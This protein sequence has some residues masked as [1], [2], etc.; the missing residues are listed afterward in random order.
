MS[1][2]WAH[3]FTIASDIPQVLAHSS[4]LHAG[5]LMCI[6]PNWVPQHSPQKTISHI[7]PPNTPTCSTAREPRVSALYRDVKK[8]RKRARG[9]C[10]ALS[11]LQSHCRALMLMAPSKQPVRRGS[12]WPMSPSKRSPSTCR[13]KACRHDVAQSHSHTVFRIRAKHAHTMCCEL[14]QHLT[15]K[16]PHV[17]APQTLQ[18][19]AALSHFTFVS[20][21][22]THLALP[23]NVQHGS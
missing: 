2:F 23:G 1:S 17:Y 15:R 5:Q 3:P 13:H 20:S 7:T 6:C 14:T 21:L 9:S 10:P 16:C 19:V 12:P 4:S 11:A 18:Q 8:A 22:S